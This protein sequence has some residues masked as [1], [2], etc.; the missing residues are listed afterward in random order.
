MTYPLK[1]SATQSL[2]NRSHKTF[3]IKMGLIRE[4][5]HC[6]IKYLKQTK[7]NFKNT[8]KLQDYTSL[9]LHLHIVLNVQKIKE[10]IEIE[11]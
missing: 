11:G 2:M 6:T 1:T 4:I 3:K 5:R 7:R 9:G 8:Q 10:M